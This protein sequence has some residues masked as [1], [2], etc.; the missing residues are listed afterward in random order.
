M[1]RILHVLF[2]SVFAACIASGVASTTCYADVPQQKIGITTIFAVPGG[3]A[4]YDG[5]AKQLRFFELTNDSLHETKSFKLPANV[6]GVAALPQGYAIATGLGRDTLDA[7][8]RVQWY[9]KD[10]TTSRSIF[11][12]SGERTQV[13]FL[14]YIDDRLWITFFDSKYITKTGY[15]TE[16]P[17]ASWRYKELFSARLGD[18]VGILDDDEV[19]VGRPYGDIQGQDGDLRLYKGEAYQELPSY[20]GVRSVTVFGGASKEIAIGDG[21]HQNYGQFAQAR[22]SLLKRDPSSG[23]FALQVIDRDPA[24]Y[25]FSHIIDFSL[26]GAT[27]LAAVGDKSI[28]IYGPEGTWAKETIYTRQAEDALF[29]AVLLGTDGNRARFAVL[30]HDL[31]VAEFSAKK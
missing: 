12:R 5:D 21:W 28:S 6:W 25:N 7:P 15:F 17:D 16:N 1:H 31:K 13:S 29:D 24:Q 22:L 23:T 27:Y 4:A 14:R 19:V 30:D 18:A 10:G 2:I 8:L 20:R 11:E 3:V 26:N 9:S